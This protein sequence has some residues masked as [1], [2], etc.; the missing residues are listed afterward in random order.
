MMSSA[1]R[2]TENGEGRYMGVGFMIV[3]SGKSQENVDELG[4][5][6]IS[7][8]ANRYLGTIGRSP[9]SMST[10]IGGSPFLL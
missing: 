4:K 8:F 1:R 3:I 2:K 10:F 6:R 9:K 7:E 5:R